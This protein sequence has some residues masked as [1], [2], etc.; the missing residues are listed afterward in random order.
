MI[1]EVPTPGEPSPD[2]AARVAAWPGAEHWREL[3]AR[4]LAEIAAR[5]GCDFAT[6]LLYTRVRAAS[7]SLAPDALSRTTLQPTAVGRGPL[8]VIVPGAFYREHPGTGADGARIH[9]ALARAGRRWRLAPIESVGSCAT[10]GAL[11]AEWLRDEGD[12]GPMVLISLSK[13]SADIRAA[14]ARPDAAT[15]FARVIAWVSLDNIAHGTPMITWLRR[16][17]WLYGIYRALFWWRGRDPAFLSSLERPPLSSALPFLEAPPWLRAYHVIG[18]P[19]TAHLAEGMARR[20]HRR[21]APYG[22]NDGVGL[23][24]DI[25]HLPGVIVPVWGADHYFH[26]DTGIDA[27]LHGLLDHIDGVL[28]QESADQGTAREATCP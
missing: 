28:L 11:L 2:L 18:F 14:L 13:G 27:V 15:C 20:W 10:N 7:D 26:P 4:A 9:T 6:A 8:Y 25:V 17:P 21:L 16:R 24:G 12:E 23:L 5:E 1:D 22:P 19:L 3:D